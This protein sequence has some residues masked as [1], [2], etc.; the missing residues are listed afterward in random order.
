VGVRGLVARDAFMA[1]EVCDSRD[2]DG[3]LRGKGF[4]AR[5]RRRGAGPATAPQSLYP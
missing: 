5:T 1:L 3:A 4:R 2:F